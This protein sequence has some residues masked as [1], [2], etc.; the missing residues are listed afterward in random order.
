VMN[1]PMSGPL[2]EHAGNPEVPWFSY[3]IL[4]GACTSLGV[5]KMRVRF[6]AFEAFMD[7]G[8]HVE[9]RGYARK[10]RSAPWKLPQ[11][12]QAGHCR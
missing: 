10:E 7:L 3:G 4:P 8:D 12:G 11:G 1:A 6:E 2:S 9:L 5:F